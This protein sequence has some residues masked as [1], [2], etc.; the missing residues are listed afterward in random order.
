MKK[1]LVLLIT[2]LT[3]SSCETE[4]SQK[5]ENFNG[6]TTTYFVEGSASTYFVSQVSVPF[7][8]KIGSTSISSSDRTY[9]IQVDPASTAI[10]GVDFSLVSNTATI[11]SGE[12]FGA[13]AVQGIFEGTTPVGSTLILKISGE[14]AMVNNKYTLTLVQACPLEADFTGDYLIEELTPYVDGPTLDTGTVVEVYKIS[15]SEF[16]RGFMSANYVLYCSTPKE[17]IFELK[18]GNVTIPAPGN[19]SNC[20]CGGNLY[21][22]N[23]TTPSTYDLADDSY[24]EV[25]FT[26]DAY[27]DCG[28]PVQTTYSFTKQ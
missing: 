20:S 21:F 14:D 3:I 22:T 12:Y 1:I 9:S 11:P 17:F 23:P 2:L 7:L 16:K 5:A 24:F 27:N 8:I 26:N 15:G 6:P 28:A 19:Q 4:D 25:T 13:V 18:C 10:E